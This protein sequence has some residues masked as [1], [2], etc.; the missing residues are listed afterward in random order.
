M[1]ELVVFHVSGND[2][3]VVEDAGGV[4]GMP[5]VGYGGEAADHVGK[6]PEAESPQ[7]CAAE[8]SA[9]VDAKDGDDDEAHDGEV[10]EKFVV[11]LYKDPD[12]SDG[13]E[14]VAEDEHVAKLLFCGDVAHV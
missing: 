6:A 9:P 11:S 5:G 14:A 13:E 8:P 10:E 2:A 1:D 12:G 7:E 3:P 4:G